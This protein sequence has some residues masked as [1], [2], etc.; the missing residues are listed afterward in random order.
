MDTASYVN[1][2]PPWEILLGF[3]EL[4]ED[5][6]FGT[7]FA[8]TDD[9]V[10][11][12]EHPCWRW[13]VSWRFSPGDGQNATTGTK[14]SVEKLRFFL[15]PKVAMCVMHVSHEKKPVK[16]PTAMDFIMDFIM[17][18][19]SCLAWI[20]LEIATILWNLGND[21]GKHP[22]QQPPK[23]LRLAPVKFELLL[24]DDEK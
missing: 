18:S 21:P 16:H 3:V 14:M 10:V 19:G 1:H 11:R 23:T 6:H 13:Q 7:R 5:N 9:W 8:A 22:S 12:W 20:S 15:T 24:R 2:L 17:V 4:P